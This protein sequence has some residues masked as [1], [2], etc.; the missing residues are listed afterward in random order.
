MLLELHHVL[1]LGFV[2][3]TQLFKGRVHA[4]FA[5]VEFTFKRLFLLDQNF[6][7]FCHE[8]LL[9]H[10]FDLVHCLPEKLRLIMDGICII[11]ESGDFSRHDDW[12]LRISFE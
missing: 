5:K 10:D 3:I 1:L 6:V 7:T 8:M 11:L 2:L 4:L 9:V 12:H